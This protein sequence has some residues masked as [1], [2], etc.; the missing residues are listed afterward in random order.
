MIGAGS[1]T[2]TNGFALTSPGPGTYL[3]HHPDQRRSDVSVLR[4]HLQTKSERRPNELL[5]IVYKYQRAHRTLRNETSA[6]SCEA[7]LSLYFT[8]IL[9][10][11]IGTRLRN[12]AYGGTL[13]ITLSIQFGVVSG[14]ATELLVVD[15]ETR[16]SAA[17]LAPPAIAP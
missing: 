5:Q 2:W 10:R 12:D 11:T 9:A 8:I 1:H 3:C 4:D 6:A 16:H 15:F 7:F 17:R 14:V 13:R